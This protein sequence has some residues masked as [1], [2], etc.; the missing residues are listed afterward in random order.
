MNYD[1]PT[2]VE[3]G[4]IPYEIRSDFRPILDILDASTDP[5]ISKR[6]FAEIAIRIFYPEYKTIPPKDMQD[7]FNKCIWFIDCGEESDGR[8]HRRLMEWGQDLHLIIPPINRVIGQEIRSIPYDYETNSGGF[9]WWSFIGA[10]QEIGECAFAQVVSIR[11]KL[12]RHKKLEKYDQEWLKRNRHLVDFK[13][14]YT[15]AD[16][17]LLKQWV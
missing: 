15:E 16:D 8:K 4:G 6:D 10:Y 1:L 3:V 9:H 11:D 13:R 7:A 14:K 2:I 5:E 17:N 12:A